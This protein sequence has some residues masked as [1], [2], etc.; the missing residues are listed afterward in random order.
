MRGDFPNFEKL[1]REDRWREMA[2]NAALVEAEGYGRWPRI[3]EIVEF[4]QHMGYRRL[5]VAY[6]VE[7]FR[8]AKLTREYLE[9][10]GLETILPPVEAI[11]PLKGEC[12]T[13]EGQARFF[14][15]A[16]TDFNIICGMCTGH[17]AIFIRSS[18]APVTSLLVRDTKLQHNPAGAL[19]TSESYFRTPL[20]R[21]HLRD[22]NLKASMC[23]DNATLDV[24]SR[25][26]TKEGQGKW[27]CVEE[28]VE[29]AHRLGAVRL[30]IVFCSGFR[31]EARILKRVLD[32]NGFNV[33]STCCKTGSVPKE[34]LGIADSQKVRP[35]NSEMI[36]N[37][38]AQAEL[39]NRENVHLVLLLGQCVGHDSA[40]MAHVEAPAVCVIA[41]DRALA[42]NPAA[43]LYALESQAVPWDNSPHVTGRISIA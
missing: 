41:K 27:S 4:S 18:A 37:P 2:H 22:S 12:S 42:H 5:G 29:L 40:T 20:Y 21:N 11:L 26:V 6:C 1:Y 7:T 38:I 9:S 15:D 34:E 14:E 25:A 8:E 23:F 10:V 19:Y 36:C 3:R 33:S 13:P 28:V 17:D 43:A 32:A 35:G 39:L 31:T 16:G 30:G 24:V